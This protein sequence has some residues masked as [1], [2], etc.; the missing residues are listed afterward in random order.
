MGKILLAG[1]ALAG[2]KNIAVA[3]S[4]QVAALVE[5]PLC[6]RGFLPKGLLRYAAGRGRTP[7]M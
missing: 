2:D 5:Q 3:L 6:L 7:A 1:G 4:W